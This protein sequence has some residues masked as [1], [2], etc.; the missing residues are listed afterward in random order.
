[1]QAEQI[2][3]R[4]LELQQK[5]IEDSTSRKPF[6]FVRSSLGWALVKQDKYA[7]VEK[8]ADLLL[9][10]LED[11]L[12]KSNPQSLKLLR[13]LMEAVGGQGRAEG[14]I[15]LN[16]EGHMLIEGMKGGKGEKCW[17]EELDTVREVAVKPDLWK[18]MSGTVV[19][20]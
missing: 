9:P 1:M 7:E 6:L 14:A 11:D 16:E 2:C 12:G 4:M 20:S 10:A 13:Q 3:R 18:S 15:E 8:T 17:Q 5:N 19:V